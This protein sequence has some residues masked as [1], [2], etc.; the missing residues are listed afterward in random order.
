MSASTS[1]LRNGLVIRNPDSGSRYRVLD[2]LGSGGFGIAYRVKQL[3]GPIL[4]RKEYCLKVTA[5]Q[6]AWHRE[7][8]FGDLLQEVPGV[9]RLWESFVW[10]RRRR[11]LLYCLKFELAEGGALGAGWT[12]TDSP[13]QRHMRGERS[14]G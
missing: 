13:G 7:A 11:A 6:T 10:P 2:Q 1:K 8:F 14:F 4:L 3:T 12:A 9:I 5:D